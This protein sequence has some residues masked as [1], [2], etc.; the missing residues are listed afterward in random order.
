MFRD[1]VLNSDIFNNLNEVKH[2]PEG[3]I[4]IYKNEWPMTLSTI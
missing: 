3:E 1:D 2:I 4:E